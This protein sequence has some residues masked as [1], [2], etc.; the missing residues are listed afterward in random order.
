MIDA[1]NPVT[2]AVG[3]IVREGGP[4]PRGVIPDDETVG[5]RAAVADGYGQRVGRGGR[6]R[7][8]DGSAIPA[9]SWRTLVD[10]DTVDSH[11]QEIEHQRIGPG[12]PPNPAHAAPLD[13]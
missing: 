9:E 3:P 4:A 13:A 10:Q 5:D 8:A 11:A 7:D 12:G 6:Q 2:P 1:G